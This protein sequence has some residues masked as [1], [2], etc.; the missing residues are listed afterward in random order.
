TAD[1]A[2]ERRRRVVVVALNGALRQQAEENEA[3]DCR[4]DPQR[5]RPPI[6]RSSRKVDVELYRIAGYHG[7]PPSRFESLSMSV[8][9][10]ACRTST[11]LVRA[12]QRPG[13]AAATTATMMPPSGIAISSH[14][15]KT[16]SKASG[17]MLPPRLLSW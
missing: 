17:V 1:A 11:T 9:H 6:E 10:S 3:R 8:G 12:A 5:R 15:A 13:I 7:F 4:E 2:R 14:G 16:S